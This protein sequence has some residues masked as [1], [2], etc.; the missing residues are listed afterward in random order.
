MSEPTI[1]DDWAN[2]WVEKA[3]KASHDKVAADAAA[4]QEESEEEDDD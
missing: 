2:S 1:R 4:K 3:H